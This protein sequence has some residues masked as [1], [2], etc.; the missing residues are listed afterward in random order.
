MDSWRK[1]GSFYRVSAFY[2]FTVYRNFSFGAEIE[3]VTCD[4]L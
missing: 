4:T 3:T 2:V 1:N